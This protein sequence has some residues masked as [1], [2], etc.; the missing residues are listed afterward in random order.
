MLSLLWVVQLPSYSHTGFPGRSE[1]G[2]TLQSSAVLVGSCGTK[3]EQR[4]IVS[5]LKVQMPSGSSAPGVCAVCSPYV[6]FL[7][8]P[9]PSM[10]VFS[11][12]LSCPWFLS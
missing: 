2:G 12:A 3:W 9:L 1:C 11:P 4:I 8:S 10:A 5:V 7:L 6:M